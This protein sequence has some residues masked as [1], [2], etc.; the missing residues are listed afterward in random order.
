MTHNNNQKVKLEECKTPIDAKAC[1]LRVSKTKA[2]I[3]TL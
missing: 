2:L 3:V 1:G